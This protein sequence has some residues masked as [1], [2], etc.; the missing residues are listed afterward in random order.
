MSN[1]RM[2]RTTDNTRTAQAKRDTLARREAR[3]LKGGAYAPRPFN[4]EQLSEEMS[5]N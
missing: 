3:A 4:A 5:A 2:T 1:A